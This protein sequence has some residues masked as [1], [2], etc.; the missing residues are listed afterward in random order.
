M[1]KPRMTK[2]EKA[3]FKSVDLQT[4]EGEDLAK[5]ILLHTTKTY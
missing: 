2:S 5:W 4:L 3:W 1:R